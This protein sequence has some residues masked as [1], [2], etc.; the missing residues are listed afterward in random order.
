[1]NQIYIRGNEIATKEYVDSLSFGGGD[2]DL[3]NYYTKE[4]INNIISET[5]NSIQ[6]EEMPDASEEN[7][8]T[9]VQYIGIT[10]ENYTTSNFYQVVEQTVVNEDG[11]ETTIYVWEEISTPEINLDKY[12]TKEY[13]NESLTNIDLPQSIYTIYINVSPTAAFSA[14]IRNTIMDYINKHYLKTSKIPSFLLIYEGAREVM[15]YTFQRNETTGDKRLEFSGHMHKAS[16]IYSYTEIIGCSQ[17][18]YYSGE[19]GSATSSSCNSS[20]TID[21]LLPTTNKYSYTPTDDYNPATKKY[22]DE[23]V[24]TSIA[25][26]SVTSMSIATSLP[27]ENIST[28]TIYLIKDE[29]ASTDSENIYNEYVYINGK[30]ENIGSTKTTVDLS[31]YYNKQEINTMIGDINSLLDAIN[32]E[33]V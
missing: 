10:N 7:V 4:E 32:G 12:A 25:G 5:N 20:K 3:S 29:T 28:S 21:K 14:S 23:T 17:T 33:E 19:L 22:V 1:M 27:T 24:A 26:I 8:G 31:N 30:W 15:L 13:V 6:V 9:I 11:S 18:I 2:A 16:G